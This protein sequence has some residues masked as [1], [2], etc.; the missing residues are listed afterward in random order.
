MEL[1]RLQRMRHVSSRRWEGAQSLPSRSM[2]MKLAVL[3]A[4]VSRRPPNQHWEIRRCPSSVVGNSHLRIR[5]EDHRVHRARSTLSGERKNLPRTRCARR[6]QNSAPCS[7]S[8]ARY[9]RRNVECSRNA[10]E[11]SQLHRD[12]SGVA[13]HLNASGVDLRAAVIPI[14]VRDDFQQ[15]ASCIQNAN[16]S[17]SIHYE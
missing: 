17:Q 1:A 13:A 11:E 12:A 10:L 14:T 2:W 9:R 3:C 15:L 4:Y 6:P 8:E 7:L 5:M 16:R